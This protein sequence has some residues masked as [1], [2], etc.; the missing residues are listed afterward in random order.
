MAAG[1]FRLCGREAL[2]GAVSFGATPALT[3]LLV[4]EAKMCISGCTA[5]GLRFFLSSSTHMAIHSLIC[6]VF[7]TQNILCAGSQQKC[8]NEQ[9][10]PTS[11]SS[12]APAALVVLPRVPGRCFS[13]CVGQVGAEQGLKTHGYQ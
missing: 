11:G 8:L 4:P 5:A 2:G 1:C 6:S 9:S 10:H 13:F 12:V 3:A 7:G